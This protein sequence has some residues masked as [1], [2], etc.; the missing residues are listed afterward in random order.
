MSVHN[1]NLNHLKTHQQHTA[2]GTENEQPAPTTK[3]TAAPQKENGLL[4]QTQNL[5]LLLSINDLKRDKS[6]RAKQHSFSSLASVVRPVHKSTMSSVT[7]S[8]KTLKP[9]AHSNL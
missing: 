7:P 3:K 1:S 4:T 5:Y 8:Q 2:G 9:A 6:R